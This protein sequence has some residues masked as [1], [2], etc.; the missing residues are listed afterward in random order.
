MSFNLILI[1]LFAYCRQDLIEIKRLFVRFVSHELRTPLNTMFMGI[2][3]LQ[4]DMRRWQCDQSS[5][6]ML[7]DLSGASESLLRIVN[8]LLDFDKLNAGVLSLD[9]TL[10]NG[11]VFVQE[12][13]A[14]FHIQVL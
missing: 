6:D 11:S 5:I 7:K 13:I 9:R 8:E 2:E 1:F 4:N 14:P 12:S 10:T 3:L